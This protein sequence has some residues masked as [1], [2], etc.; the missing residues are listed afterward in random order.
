MVC[1]RIWPSQWSWE[2]GNTSFIITILQD[3]E[4]SNNLPNTQQELS[5]KDCQLSCVL[6][7]PCSVRKATLQ[8]DDGPCPCGRGG[9]TGGL[10]VLCCQ[11]D[12]Q[13]PG[14]PPLHEPVLLSLD[15]PVRS[16]L[17][18][19][20]EFSCFSDVSRPWLHLYMLLFFVALSWLQ[21]WSSA[22]VSSSV[23]KPFLEMWP[24]I[25]QP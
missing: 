1:Y 11:F 7:G 24:L 8:A 3:S 14:T 12:D 6:Q 2:A 20:P 9:R 25:G 5:G 16:V 10:G 21:T 22:S 23:H 17:S 4:K 15:V 13:E 19:S 18:I